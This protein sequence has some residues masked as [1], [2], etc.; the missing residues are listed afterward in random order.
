MTD[1]VMTDKEIAKEL[2]I[3]CL[4]HASFATWV[5]PTTEGNSYATAGER[6]GEFYNAILKALQEGKITAFTEPRVS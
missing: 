6:I 5:R 4:N 1:I 2:A 3:A